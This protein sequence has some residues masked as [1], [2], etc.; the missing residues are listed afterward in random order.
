M[1]FVSRIQCLIQGAV[2]ASRVRIAAISFQIKFFFFYKKSLKFN[3]ESFPFQSCLGIFLFP[4]IGGKLLE[5][6]W[7][8]FGPQFCL[9]FATIYMHPA[10][11]YLSPCLVDVSMLFLAARSTAQ[12][13]NSSP[14]AGRIRHVSGKNIFP[15]MK[16]IV[17]LS[18]R[19]KQLKKQLSILENCSAVG[20]IALLP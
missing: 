16:E 1:E 14:A 19:E 20:E 9:V 7:P 12:L 5:L 18:C 8:S 11:H 13:E 3:S 4:K 15:Q 10:L 17:Q 6:V 2:V